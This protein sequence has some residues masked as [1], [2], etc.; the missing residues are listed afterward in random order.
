M[1]EMTHQNLPALNRYTS[2]TQYEALCKI[3]ETKSIVPIVFAGGSSRTLGALVRS[4]W[5]KSEV[6]TDEQG[7]TR[8][9]WFVTP[10]GLHAM[11]LYEIKKAEEDRERA[12][13]KKAEAELRLVVHA[14]L[15][16]EDRMKFHKKYVDG[17]MSE[18]HRLEGLF[19]QDSRITTGVKNVLYSEVLREFKRKT[20][21][22]HMC[23]MAK[24]LGYDLEG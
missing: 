3:R 11:K 15:E 17:L 9:G 13:T 22:E 8:E 7:V 10:E 1:T 21:H 20:T 12:E 16:V 24:S 2:E 19:R 18:L 5:I 6:F 14:Y 23:E 4:M